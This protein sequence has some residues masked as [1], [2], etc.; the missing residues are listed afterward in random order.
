[1]RRLVICCTIWV[2]LLCIL[3]KS[4]HSFTEKRIYKNVKKDGLK[5]IITDHLSSPSFDLLCRFE[6]DTMTEVKEVSG[7]GFG[8]FATIAIPAGT[9]LGFYKGEILSQRLYKKRYPHGDSE[10]T[11]LL[12]PSSQRRNLIYVDAVNPST[13][14]RL[15]FVNHDGQ[16]PNIITKIVYAQNNHF[17]QYYHLS[18]SLADVWK[19][20]KNDILQ[21][22]ESIVGHNRISNHVTNDD[23]NE[24]SFITHHHNNNVEAN[25]KSILTSSNTKKKVVPLILFET[26]HAVIAGEELCF[27]YGPRYLAA[28]K[29]Q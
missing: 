2:I 13:S 12:N 21:S 8:L 10:Y 20:N 3:A 26:V 17:D 6:L 27:D 15:R 11:F 18:S 4:L 9:P 28:W 14:N 16:R 29:Q 7:K 19:R 24:D 5:D 1:M 22:S 25:S 23:Q